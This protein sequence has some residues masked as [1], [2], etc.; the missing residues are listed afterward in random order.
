MGREK[1][2]GRAKYD[3]N[4]LGKHNFDINLNGR[5][6]KDWY[7][8]VS[9]FNTFDPGNVKLQF[10]PYA[11]ITGFYTGT[12]THKYGKDSKVTF[13]YRHTAGR[14]L[15]NTVK[16]APYIWV[17]N[18]TIKEFDGF[19]IGKDNYGSDD[20]IVTYLN[21]KNGETET[22]HYD[23]LGKY[24]TY[25]GKIMWDHRIDD[26]TMFKLRAKMSFTDRNAIN[27]NTQN[28]LKN[29]T[30]EYADGSGTYQGDVQR[31]LVQIQEVGIQDYMLV[32]SLEKKLGKHSL[33]LG[34]FDYLEHLDMYGSSTQYDHEVKANPRKLL[35]KGNTFFNNNS[36]AQFA[37]GWENKVGIYALD[38][39]KVS[40]YVRFTY[41]GRLEYFYLSADNSMDKR[42][43]GFYIGAPIPNSDKTVSITNRKLKG[44]NYSVSLLPTIN[45][46]KNFGFDGE[47]NYITMFRHIQGFYG[48]NAPLQNKRPHILGRAGLFYN[49]KYFN[50]VTSFAYSFRKG[51]SGRITVTSDNP[52]EGSVMVPY[53]QAIQT[54]GWKTDLMITPVKWF[55]L[56]LIFTLQD[57]KLHKYEFSAF[58]KDYDYSG[59]QMTNLAK[60][61][62]DINPPLHIRQVQHLGLDALSEQKVC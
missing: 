16:Q 20:G 24:H 45:F 60:V 32:A 3:F 8:S 31:R 22:R 18:G 43:Q 62:L 13:F 51:D 23:E 7:F 53:E 58:G 35:F 34:V 11:D 25:E 2:S 40:D 52:E 6:A 47:I 57:P 1:L 42:F 49:H 59:K 41:G 46:T 36:S 10:T 33:N 44:L 5:I 9:A 30:R 26:N 55:S 27:D 48:A 28:I 21:M 19:R 14:D 29:Q 4:T 54:I 15:M 17:G 56:N 38:T 50:V 39:W 12:V 37:K 61:L